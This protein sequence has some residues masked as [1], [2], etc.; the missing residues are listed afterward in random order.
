VK[1]EEAIYFAPEKT[2]FKAQERGLQKPGTVDVVG[3]SPAAKA[4]ID[5]TKNSA[6]KTKPAKYFLSI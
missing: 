2:L 3:V 5:I 6:T 4:V 1:A